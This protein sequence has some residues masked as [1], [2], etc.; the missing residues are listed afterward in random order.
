M[1]KGQPCRQYV[2]SPNKN[3][4]CQRLEWA[5]LVGCLHASCHRLMP[6][7]WHVLT[8]LRKTTWASFGISDGL[9]LLDFACSF[10]SAS[11]PCNN[12]EEFSVSSVNPSS[13]FWNWGWFGDSPLNLQLL[14]KWGH[15]CE[16]C[17]QMPLN[18]IFLLFNF[19]LIHFFS[20]KRC[21][22]CHPGRMEET[23]GILKA[24]MFSSFSH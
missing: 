18:T 5:S 16:N 10:P 3:S 1:P 14:L 24:I 23:V 2:M 12:P 6:G 4:G 9:C 17:A 11:F 15:S 22:S 21:S 7:V 13:K 8:S 19:S 20:F